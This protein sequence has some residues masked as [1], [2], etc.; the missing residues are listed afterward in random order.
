MGLALNTA[1]V[2][3]PTCEMKPNTKSLAIAAA[4]ALTAIAT[5]FGAT[6]EGCVPAGGAD[7]RN[8]ELEYGWTVLQIETRFGGELDLLVFDEEGD[9]IAKE[10]EVGSDPMIE[11]FVPYAQEVQIVLV[12]K[13]DSTTC[14][15]G[16]VE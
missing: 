3:S 1:E 10:E 14:Y 12:N 6:F 8:I 15:T 5:A 4:A 16:T 13:S 2:S 7:A 11:F 9:L